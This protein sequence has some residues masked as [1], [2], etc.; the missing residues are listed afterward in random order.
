MVEPVE[1]DEF[2]WGG[3]VPK[4]VV[5]GQKALEGGDKQSGGLLF[6]HFVLV[7]EWVLLFF[8]EVGD[9]GEGGAQVV[10]EVA[11]AVVDADEVLVVEPSELEESLNFLTWI[12]DLL[13]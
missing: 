4:P 6:G 1:E 12:E 3:E 11:R 13:R 5:E 10:V 9:I 7:E 8:D 2:G